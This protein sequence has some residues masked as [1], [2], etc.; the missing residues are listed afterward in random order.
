MI[1]PRVSSSQIE[2]NLLFS[3]GRND[4]YILQTPEK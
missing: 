4:H 3:P 1:K 2:I